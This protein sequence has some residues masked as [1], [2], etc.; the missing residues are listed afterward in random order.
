MVEM[1]VHAPPAAYAGASRNDNVGNLQSLNSTVV[2]HAVDGG[3]TALL[4][5]L[6]VL[7]SLR[8]RGIGT[9]MLVL[10]EAEAAYFGCT[11][12]EVSSIFRPEEVAAL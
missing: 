10:A 12:V 8:R 11:S 7:P 4:S 1:R 5:T 9:Q 2:L 6:T 3:R